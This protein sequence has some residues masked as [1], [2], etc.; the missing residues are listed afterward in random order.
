MDVDIMN[1]LALGGVKRHADSPLPPLSVDYPSTSYDPL[2][3]EH[4]S[5]E[6]SQFK[7]LKIKVSFPVMLR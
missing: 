1:R 7:K 2:K 3:P 4:G 6:D 5:D